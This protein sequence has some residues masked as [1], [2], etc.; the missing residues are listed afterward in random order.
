[1]AATTGVGA[2]RATGRRL[3][4]ELEPGRTPAQLAMLLEACRIADRLEELNGLLLARRPSWVRLSM[5]RRAGDWLDDP[6]HDH[7]SVELVVSVD[8][9]LAESRQQALV[10]R[11]LLLAVTADGAAGAKP[12]PKGGA[13]DGDD[14]LGRIRAERERAA[15]AG[16]P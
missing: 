4:R 2:L 8:G 12:M 5:P 3:Y 1:M 10:Y 13:H 6:D 7:I 11:Q 9:L 16:R 14:E 15:A